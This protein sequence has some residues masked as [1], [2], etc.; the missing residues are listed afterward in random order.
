M[1]S[2]VIYVNY[3]IGFSYCHNTGPSNIDPLAIICYIADDRNILAIAN[4][5]T[6]C[7]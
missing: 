5:A 6:A 7:I 2:A 1:F 3:I 4:I